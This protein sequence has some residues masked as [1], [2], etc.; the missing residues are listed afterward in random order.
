MTRRLGYAIIYVESEG[1]VMD[2]NMKVLTEDEILTNALRKHLAH[3]GNDRLVEI[4]IPL[5]KEV[6]ERNKK[7]DLD[8][9]IELPKAVYMIDRETL[10][11]KQFAPVYE[12]TSWLQLYSFLGDKL[13]LEMIEKKKKGEL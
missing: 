7:F 9:E 5:A 2:E 1:S 8:S 6:I 12:I 10:E 3:F 11:S 4:L 13:I